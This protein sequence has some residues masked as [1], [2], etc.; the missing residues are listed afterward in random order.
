M[1]RQP[2]VSCARYAAL[3]VSGLAG[4]ASQTQSSGRGMLVT[5]FAT[6]HMDD[7]RLALGKIALRVVPFASNA[8]KR[9]PFFRKEGEPPFP[10]DFYLSEI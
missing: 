1:S 10:L 9:K 2:R 7:S 6:P 8:G 4:Q 5:R 3:S